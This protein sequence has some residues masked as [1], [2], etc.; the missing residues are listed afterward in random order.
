MGFATVFVVPSNIEPL[1]WLAIFLICAYVIAKRAPRMVFLHGLLLGLVNC[2][3]VTSVHVALFDQYLAHH[4]REAAM[5]KTMT[6]PVSPRVLMACIGPI[7]GV[8]SGAVIG[9]L[10]LLAGLIVRR[11]RPAPAS[12]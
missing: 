11:G 4:A 7:V 9:L 5:M 10:A 12:A 2:V 1:L 6:L 8:I 3:W